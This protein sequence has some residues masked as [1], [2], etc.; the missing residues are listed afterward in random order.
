MHPTHLY[1]EA[2]CY[3]KI[4]VVTPEFY[5]RLV[6]SLHSQIQRTGNMSYFFNTGHDLLKIFFNKQLHSFF[7][8]NFQFSAVCVRPH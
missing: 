3:L 5:T 6:E 7:Q 2:F 8:Y 1:Y 4:F